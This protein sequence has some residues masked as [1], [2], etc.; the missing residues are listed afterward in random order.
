MKKALVITV[1][2]IVFL[3][4][5]F[6]QSN[7]F[8][9]YNIA[10]IQ[11][12]LYIIFVLFIGLFLGKSY[13]T[14]LGVI[15][16]LLIDLFIGKRI[17]LNGIMLGIC[18]MI[19]GILDKSFSKDNRI[20]FMLMTFFVTILCEIINYTLQIILLSAEPAFTEFMKIVIVEAIYNT[21]LLII[22][23][24]LIQKAGERTEEILSKE[25]TLMKYY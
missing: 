9:W 20:T 17:G 23:Y 3:L 24:P 21:I 1:F 18:G 22:L 15:F 14:A 6:L 5:Y 10:G 16:G 8:S 13:G 19:G 7:F 25:K 11:P 12:N 4:L 2:F